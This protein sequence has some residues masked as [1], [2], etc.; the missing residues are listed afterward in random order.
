M[1][2][3]R[4]L[5]VFGICLIA[6]GLTAAFLAAD[7]DRAPDNALAVADGSALAQTAVWDWELADDGLLHAVWFFDGEYDLIGAILDDCGDVV[8]ESM[9]EDDGTAEG[10]TPI[11]D[12]LS[13]IVA[14][15]SP[16]Q[17]PSYLR[18]ISAYITQVNGGTM[19]WVVYEDPDGNGP[20]D[21]FIWESST[22]TPIAGAWND[23]SVSG[24]PE[25]D[26]PIV[27]GS[28]CVGLRRIAGGVNYVGRDE[29]N[30][31]DHSW[32]LKDTQGWRPMNDFHAGNAMIRA[33]V[34]NC[35]GTTTTTT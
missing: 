35:Q 9:I 12:G 8:W 23:A 7:L 32:V 33:N 29:D 3:N 10:E 22:F 30:D 27:S 28:W 25:F 2:G 31:D 20:P 13:A 14:C 34:D 6:G 18:E 21:G 16:S 4:L 24:I 17:Y 5:T 1:P 26:D 15:L 11:N 19:R